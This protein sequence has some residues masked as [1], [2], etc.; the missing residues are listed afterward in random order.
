MFPTLRLNLTG[1]IIRK[2]L[3]RIEGNGESMMSPKD[4][5]ESLKAKIKSWE[6]HNTLPIINKVADEA[7]LALSQAKY[8]L[9]PRKQGSLD[10]PA[11]DAI[12]S[13][14][15]APHATAV[16]AKMYDDARQAFH[17]PNTFALLA[18]VRK[19]GKVKY[20]PLPFKKNFKKMKE[21]FDHMSLGAR[22]SIMRKISREH[23]D[24]MDELF[25]L[26]DHE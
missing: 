18:V 1:E 24:E 6:T 14:A 19:D 9:L 17:D 25:G 22:R 21:S 12:I 8:E 4:N 16:A 3:R 13:I 23:R 5:S 20:V 2:N 11:P 7:A 15:S 26:L 10:N